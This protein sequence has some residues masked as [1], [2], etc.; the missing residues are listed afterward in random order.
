[1][2][3]LDMHDLSGGSPSWVNGQLQSIAVNPDYGKGFLSLATSLPSGIIVLIQDLS[4]YGSGDI[5]AYR[6]KVKL[7]VIAFSSILSGVRQV[8][9]HTSRVALGDGFSNIEFPGYNP[10]VGV[11]IQANTPVKTFSVCMTPAVFENLTRKNSTE[12]VEM[13]DFLDSSARKKDAP[14]RSRQLDIAQKLCGHQAFDSFMASPDDTLFLEAKALELVALQLRQ[15]EYLTGKTPQ[16]QP[17]A[18][19]MEKIQYACEILKK[20]MAEPPDK[21]SLARRVGL[22]HDQLFQGFKE[23]VGLCPFAYLRILRL[24]KA[25]ELIVSRK[26]NVTEAAFA[27]GYSSLSHFTN[28]FRKEF[29]KTPKAFQKAGEKQLFFMEEDGD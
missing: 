26:C 17:V 14:Q 5:K 25:K 23:F 1:M 11:R 20:K 18:H 9:C 7:P 16:K 13:L 21:L 6:S 4:L 10:S 27:V 24:E 12:L 2:V 29:G 22:N 15:L 8:Y 3:S 19:H 28:N